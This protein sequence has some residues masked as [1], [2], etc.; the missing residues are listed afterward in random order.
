MKKMLCLILLL[1]ACYPT[2]AQNNEDRIVI[3]SYVKETN[4]ARGDKL[5]IDKL[6]RVVSNYGIGGTSF[7]HRFIITANAVELESATTA[8]IPARTVTNYSVTIYIGDAVDNIIFSTYNVEIQGIGKTKKDAYYSA[9]KKINVD[10]VELEIAIDKA[11]KRIVEYYNK[12]AGDIIQ[13]AKALVAQGNYSDAVMTL[14]QIPTVCDQYYIAQELISEYA[15][16]QIYKENEDVL[17]R[18]ES[19]WQ[20]SPNADGALQAQQILTS[21]YLPSED[22]ISRVNALNNQMGSRLREVEDRQWEQEK[23]QVDAQ[24][25]SARRAQ[26]NEFELEKMR[27]NAAAK[28]KPAPVYYNIYWW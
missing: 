28:K 3:T 12:N 2:F 6:N 26:E 4:D 7:D 8:T 9:L 27:I 5:L 19:A 13:R 15:Q 16:T 21:L 18:A 24:I 10:D 11:K 1:I 22:V 23:K 14:Y 25:A 17:L 20:A